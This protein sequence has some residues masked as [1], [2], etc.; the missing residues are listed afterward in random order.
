M[1]SKSEEF[2]GDGP[3]TPAGPSSAKRPEA[4]AGR[5]D[6]N[7]LAR[8]AQLEG[9]A[10]VIE[11]HLR[12]EADGGE[13]WSWAFDDDEPSEAPGVVGAVE[14]A[15]VLGDLV[16]IVGNGGASGAALLR[17]HKVPMNVQV[18]FGDKDD[19]ANSI[20]RAVLKVGYTAKN[21]RESDRE[22]RDLIGNGSEFWRAANPQAG[23]ES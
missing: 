16:V 12:D 13:Y 3:E 9:R 11:H 2:R 4:T 5:V 6:L 7:A 17:G 20:R 1:T 23:D 10:L 19:P 14:A 15:A 18:E 22:G 21:W 8:R